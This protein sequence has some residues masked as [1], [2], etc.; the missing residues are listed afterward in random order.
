MVWGCVGGNAGAVLECG[1]GERA[2]LQVK[3]LGFVCVPSLSYGHELRVV[4]LKGVGNTSSRDEITQ[5]RCLVWTQRNVEEL[6][7]LGGVWRR[8]AKRS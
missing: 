7:Y 6:R 3:A 1:G 8:K 2:E 4:T 5:K